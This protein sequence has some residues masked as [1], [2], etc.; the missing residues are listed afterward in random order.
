MAQGMKPL[1]YTLDDWIQGKGGRREQTAQ[2]CPQATRAVCG[3]HAHSNNNAVK[4]KK[5]P[6]A[7][8]L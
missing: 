3:T 2:S 1:L 5:N 7:A 8:K 4:T 6:K